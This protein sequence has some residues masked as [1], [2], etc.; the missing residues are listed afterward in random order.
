MNNIESEGNYENF[1]V[2]EPRSLSCRALRA[3]FNGVLCFFFWRKSAKSVFFGFQ[4][5]RGKGS[6]GV[7]RSVVVQEA[8]P[9]WS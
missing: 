4:A 3:L 9:N 5:A 6:R 2:H 7:G 1:I 8:C